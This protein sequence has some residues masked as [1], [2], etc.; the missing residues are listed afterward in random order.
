MAYKTWTGKDL[1]KYNAYLKNINCE[2]VGF[3]NIGG[4]FEKNNPFVEHRLAAYVFRVYDHNKNCADRK[5][6][7]SPGSATLKNGE[8]KGLVVMLAKDNKTGSFFFDNKAVDVNKITIAHPA[9]AWVASNYTGATEVIGEQVMYEHQGAFHRDCCTFGKNG[10]MQSALNR[11]HIE[12]FILPTVAK[13]YSD[14][15]KALDAKNGAYMEE[16][17]DLAASLAGFGVDFTGE[18]SLQE[19][20]GLTANEGQAIVDAIRQSVNPN[21]N[22]EF[23]FAPETTDGAAPTEA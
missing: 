17:T 13:S 23:T 2:Q 15:I 1:E 14:E 5:I 18:V 7:T 9:S 20:Q 21:A 12:K 3:I 4:I 22:V 10:E 16:E 19:N 11:D 8:A 6:L